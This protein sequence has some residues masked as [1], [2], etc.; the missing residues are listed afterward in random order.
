MVLRE[1][2]SFWANKTKVMANKPKHAQGWKSFHMNCIQLTRTSRTK[3]QK[4]EQ[5]VHQHTTGT[6]QANETGGGFNMNAPLIMNKWIKMNIKQLF[7]S[8]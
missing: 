7:I 5:S 3:T 2:H 8:F 4:R 6:P 1:S